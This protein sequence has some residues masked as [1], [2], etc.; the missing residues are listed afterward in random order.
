MA[1]LELGHARGRGVRNSFVPDPLFEW[2]LFPFDRLLN[3]PAGSSARI[4]LAVI[5]I[6]EQQRGREGHTL[7]GSCGPS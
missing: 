4:R 6:L 2:D 5:N 1:D 7:I 3:K